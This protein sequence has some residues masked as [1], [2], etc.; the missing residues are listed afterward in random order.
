MESFCQAGI[1]PKAILRITL[2]KG[3]VWPE[4][5]LPHTISKCVPIAFAAAVSTFSEFKHSQSGESR[6]YTEKPQIFTQRKRYC[7][8]WQQRNCRRCVTGTLC[9]FVLI[10]S[11]VL[12]LPAKRHASDN[13]TETARCELWSWCEFLLLSQRARQAAS[14][15]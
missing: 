11:F 5:E 3:L 8:H 15:P 12:V 7:K 2:S 13:V 14:Q 4:T 6:V 1:T 10:Q 9:N